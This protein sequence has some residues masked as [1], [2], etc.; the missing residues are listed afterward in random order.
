MHP[1]SAGD[2]VAG[3]PL[4]DAQ[5]GEEG[6]QLRP[7]Q[8]RQAVQPV[9]SPHPGLQP[10]RHP[11]RAPLLPGPARL[12][13]ALHCHSGPYGRWWVSSSLFT[14]CLLYTVTLGLMDVGE[15]LPP[16]LLPA[17]STLSLWA[18]WALV[19]VFLLE[20]LL[21][22]TLI[23]GLLG[24]GEC[25]PP[26]ILTARHCHSGPSGCWWVSSSLNT[27]CSTLSL[28]AFWVL[29]SVFLLEY[30]L[31]DTLTLGL[32]GVGECLPPWILAA[33]H[34]HSGPYGCWWVSSS[35]FTSCLL[36]TVTLGLMGVGE[37]L[38]PWI[39]TARHSHSGPSG[40][41]WVSSSLNTYCSTLSLW[42]FWVLVSVFLLE[43]LL[44]DTLTLGLL[45][46]GECLPPW[47]L[48]ALH[49]HSGPYGRWWVS[50]SLNTY[51]STLSLWAFWVLVSV[52]LLEYLLPALHCHS[53]PSGCWWVF[54]SL[55]TYSS[56][57][58]YWGSWVLVNVFLLEHL[59]HYTHSGLFGCWCVSWWV[60]SSLNTYCLLYTVTLDLLG[61]GECRPPWILTALH[62]HSGPSG[63]WWMSSSL[64]TYCFAFS[65]WAFWVSVS[66]SSLFKP[67]CA[68]FHSESWWMCSSLFTISFTLSL[69]AFWVL[70][71][72]FLFVY[73]QFYPLTLGL[74]VVGKFLPCCLPSVSTLSLWAFWVLVSVFLVVYRQFYT[75]TLG[76]GCWWVSSLLFTVSSTLSL[77]AFWVLVSICSP[78]AVHSH[79]GCWWISS[80]LFTA[81]CALSFLV[82]WVL[83]FTA[84]STRSLWALWVLVSVVLVVCHL[85][86]ILT[87]DPLGVG[88]CCPLCLPPAVH[89]HS[90]PSGCWWVLSSLLTTC[91]TLSLWTL[92]VLVSVVL[93]VYCLQHARFV[94]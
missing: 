44:L 81:C 30:L 12:G 43:Y 45:G 25:L 34:C 23:L 8:Q 65:P 48:T 76:L 19:S 28:W 5:P 68:F 61:V 22:D 77:W 41:W 32:L 49:C 21:L 91:C 75:L 26:W 86:Y 83:V 66:T 52:F 59:L 64:N 51:C 38:P 56:T 35:L 57:L 87:L 84:C 70:V 14:S 82:F 80:L 11:G 1:G 37:C 63:C 4:Q 78:P 58:S 42:A 90:G 74:L 29:V 20:Y 94:L 73:R 47:I 79:S 85:L 69:W 72:Y 15:C 60:F 31:L 67:C 71:R 3:G 89:S 39:L 40:C 16:C 7:H 54:S 17:C 50:S 92:W 88:E 36:Y 18:L 9:H 93:V 24:V 46:V 2:R 10:C 27:Y 53:A 13:P 33:L 55:N 6:Q 62:C